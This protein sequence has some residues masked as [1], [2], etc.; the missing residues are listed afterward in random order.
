M[1]GFLNYRNW[2]LEGRRGGVREE[3]NMK[4]EWETGRGKQGAKREER[5][6]REK[7][8]TRW[9][10]DDDS[11]GGKEGGWMGAYRKRSDGRRNNKNRD[12]IHGITDEDAGGF[13]TLSPRTSQSFLDAY[14]G[15]RPPVHAK[16][17][18]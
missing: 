12:Y 14:P 17:A 8:K 7:Q 13:G 15:W 4:G 3:A 18:N 10:G 11:D 2:G 16:R 1:G 5:I 6:W 9:R